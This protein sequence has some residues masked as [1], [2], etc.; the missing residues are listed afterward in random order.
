MDD[1]LS[2]E[3]ESDTDE[4]IDDNEHK[5]K[6]Y[7]D[8]MDCFPVFHNLTHIE[9]N[10][11]MHTDWIQVVEIL[12]RCPKLQILV[13]DKGPPCLYH[14]KWR[15][16]SKPQSVPKCI[17]SHF[18]TC[19]INN[20]KGFEGEF[21]FASY[22]MQNARFLQTMAISCNSLVD[23]EEKF[24]MLKRLSLYTRRSAACKLFFE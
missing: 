17:S 4:D 20:Y 9:L 15:R 1:S 2:D 3:D 16:W 11:G 22:I 19:R 5:N 7:I 12:K 10:Y 18:T 21:Q 6:S 8:F 24:K 14:E 23:E 13:I